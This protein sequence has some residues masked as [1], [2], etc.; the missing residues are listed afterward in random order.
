MKP[1]ASIVAMKFAWGK[2]PLPSEDMEGYLDKLE[3]MLMTPY[4][5]IYNAIGVKRQELNVRSSIRGDEGALRFRTRDGDDILIEVH[6][7][8][9]FEVSGKLK[10][11]RIPKKTFRFKRPAMGLHRGVQGDIVNYIEDNLPGV[12][13]FVVCHHKD[14]CREYADEAA[15]GRAHRINGRKTIKGVD[16]PTIKDYVGPMWNGTDR[17]SNPELRYDTWELYDLLTR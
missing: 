7:D 13:K 11:K 4:P 9:M 16:A 17:K 12:P 6:P 1:N 3:T 15:L 8:N 14:G 10:G 5:A 2:V